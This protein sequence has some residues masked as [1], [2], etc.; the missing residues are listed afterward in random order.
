MRFFGYRILHMLKNEFLRNVNKNTHNILKKEFV[1]LDILRN[2]N[3]NK[4]KIII[5]I[6]LKKSQYVLTTK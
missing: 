4:S 5:S 2:Y 3:E 6:K 1:L